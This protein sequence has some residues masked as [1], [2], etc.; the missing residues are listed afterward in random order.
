MREKENNRWIFFLPQKISPLFSFTCRLSQP[1]L[2]NL[3]VTQDHHLKTCPDPEGHGTQVRR[4]NQWAES[5]LRLQGSSASGMGSSRSRQRREE[6]GWSDSWGSGDNIRNT[7][8]PLTQ[9]GILQALPHF[10]LPRIFQVVLINPHMQMTKT[11]LEGL[12][13]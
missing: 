5:Q 7:Q 13:N 6:W 9:L 3:N 4:P 2:H 10:Y 8:L 12:D 11:G 1:S